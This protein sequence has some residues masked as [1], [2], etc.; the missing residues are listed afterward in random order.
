MIFN[1][2]DENIYWIN[3]CYYINI[4]FM[5]KIISTYLSIFTFIITT[6][7]QNSYNENKLSPFVELINVFGFRKISLSSF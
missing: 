7:Y 3:N 2:K 4:D 5:E 6:D 1:L